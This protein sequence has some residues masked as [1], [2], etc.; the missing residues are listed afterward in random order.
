MP[1][2]VKTQLWELAFNGESLMTR[3]LALVRLSELDPERVS[4]MYRQVTTECPGDR[5]SSVNTITVGKH[6]DRK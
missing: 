6:D 2:Q 3:V 5:D 4:E 1:T